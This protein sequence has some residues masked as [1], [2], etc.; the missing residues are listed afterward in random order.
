MV[1]AFTDESSPIPH[2][3]FDSVFS[4]PFYAMHLDLLPRVDLASHRP[5]MDY[6]FGHLNE[7]F[8][9]GKSHLQGLISVGRARLLVN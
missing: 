4:A 1:F 2:W 7:T 8:A 3:T 5:Y 6:V 9:A